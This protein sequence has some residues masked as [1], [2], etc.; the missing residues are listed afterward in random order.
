MWSASDDGNNLND[1]PKL[2]NPRIPA[3]YLHPTTATTAIF[4]PRRHQKDTDATLRLCHVKSGLLILRVRPRPLRHPCAV[5][6][7]TPYVRA[8]TPGGILMGWT[9]SNKHPNP[10][11]PSDLG[12]YLFQLPDV[13]YTWCFTVLHLRMGHDGFLHGSVT[14]SR[15]GGPPAYLWWHRTKA[16]PASHNTATQ[17]GG[18]RGAYPRG[19]LQGFRA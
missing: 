16:G 13:R 18:N 2:R 8:Y 9:E 15:P 6:L 17:V 7:R 12:L 19:L 11:L 14:F 3:F 1:N 10:S 4:C 5:C